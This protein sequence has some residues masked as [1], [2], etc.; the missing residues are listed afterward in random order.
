MMHVVGEEWRL[1]SLAQVV[2]CTLE[3]G[4]VST[5]VTLPRGVRRPRANCGVLVPPLMRLPAAPAAPMPASLG[6]ASDRA[7]WAEFSN[8]KGMMCWQ[9]HTNAG[10][11]L[12]GRQVVG[13]CHKA[14]TLA[15]GALKLSCTM[16]SHAISMWNCLSSDR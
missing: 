11:G 13:R 10:Q 7:C 15:G 8:Q 4:V 12:Q 6:V 14:H 5:S 1:E 16:A 3:F 2:S 9:H